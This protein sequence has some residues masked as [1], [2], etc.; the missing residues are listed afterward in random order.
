MPKQPVNDA[1]APVEPKAGVPA[2]VNP[3]WQY[4]PEGELVTPRIQI[5][6][7]AEEGHVKPGVFVNNLTGE[8]LDLLQCVLVGMRRSRS[9]FRKPFK[10]EKGVPPLCKSVDFITGIGEPGGTCCRWDEQ[11]KMFIPVCPKAMFGHEGARDDGTR[12]DCQENYDFVGYD[13]SGNPFV[14]SVHGASLKPARAFISGAVRKR[15]PLYYTGVEIT[16]E[17]RTDKGLYWVAVFK[18][19]GETPETDWPELE[20]SSRGLLAA[21]ARI[22]AETP[23]GND[24]G[25]AAAY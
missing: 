2:T 14:F 19:V 8:E 17:K 11:E 6:Q 16:L 22:P 7:V 9:L 21:L 5:L 20:N 12:P 25:G 3:D 15:K 4:L 1:L 24:A 10:K 13:I 23:V 18:R